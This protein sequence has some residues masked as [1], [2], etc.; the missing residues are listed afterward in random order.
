MLSQVV[1]NLYPS[2]TENKFTCPARKA[3]VAMWRQ[4]RKPVKKGWLEL[5]GRLKDFYRLHG[6]SNV[7]QRYPDDPALGTWVSR[8]RGSKYRHFLTDEQRKL[9]AEVEFSWELQKER[10]DRLWNESYEKLKEY[11]SLHGHCDVPTL[12]GRGQPR[13]LGYWVQMQKQLYHQGLLR[14]DRTRMLDAL[15]LAWEKNPRYVWSPDRDVEAQ[16]M[17]WRENYK[18]LVAFVQTYGH[19]LVPNLF[20]SGRAEC[21]GRWVRAQ[22]SNYLQ[23]T[24]P[25]HRKKL[26]DELGF[27][28]TVLACGHSSSFERVSR[29]A[30]NAMYARLVLYR[31]IHGNCLVP[32]DYA[33]DNELARWV[34][35]QR[36]GLKVGSIHPSRIER[37]DAL[38]F[39][40]TKE[41]YAAYWSKQFENLVAYQREHN[42][43]FV[44][45]PSLGRLLRWTCAQRYLYR[46]RLLAKEQEERLQS[47]GFDWRRQTPFNPPETAASTA[48]L[49]A[50]EEWGDLIGDEIAVHDNYDD[51][52][53][54]V[55]PRAHRKLPN[56]PLA[57]KEHDLASERECDIGLEDSPREM[58][59]L[60]A[61]RYKCQY[62]YR[63]F[64]FLSCQGQGHE[65][66]ARGDEASHPSSDSARES[67]TA[68]TNNPHRAHRRLPL[69]AHGRRLEC[70]NSS[71]A[72]KRRTKS[73]DDVECH[74]DS[75]EPSIEDQCHSLQASQNPDPAPS[76]SSTCELIDDADQERERI[77]CSVL[78][79]IGTSVRMQYDGYGWVAG[80]IVRF[81]GVYRVRY[82]DG[83]EEDFLDDDKELADVVSQAKGRSKGSSLG[84]TILPFGTPVQKYFPTHGWF[85]GEIVAFDGVYLVRHDDGDEEELFYD[86]PE[87][88]AMVANAEG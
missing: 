34:E 79:P 1:R 76:V 73:I 82:E 52:E 39:L 8:Q 42:T 6:H 25:D 11:K 27:V 9:L 22:R 46:Q 78:F 37:L 75:Q 3:A 57:V 32:S 40:M 65:S 31:R 10:F 30:W 4:N 50:P 16:E 77:D 67:R 24:L 26:L 43:T 88:A 29:V 85:A 2:M 72:T 83:D 56:N 5:Y 49:K 44:S 21:L 20:V 19:A 48:H 51:S 66:Q 59:R 17:L 64:S 47:I 54:V 58:R 7:P 87:L 71:D 69:P 35:A 74:C 15:G 53:N 68:P 81:E 14:D 55:N 41:S 18:K 45:H 28:W 61:Q 60:S 33:E 36:S 12:Y 62:K 80:T 63:T 86:S 38:G 13:A 84:G 70:D 23:D